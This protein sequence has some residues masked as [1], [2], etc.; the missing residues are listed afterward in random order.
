QKHAE[1]LSVLFFAF[2][3]AVVFQ[4]IATSLT[5]QGIATGGPYDNAAAYP[6]AIAILMGILLVPIAL[7]IKSTAI[8]VTF[9]E[10]KR[11]ALMLVIFSLYLLGLGILGY[12]ISTPLMLISV[13]MI[14]GIRRPIELVLSGIG[15]SLLM[16]L[17]FES[18][19]KVVLPGGMLGLH[20]AW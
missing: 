11:P 13:M 15:V 12:H 10:L 7:T 19:L 2:I 14:S 8:G 3:I 16:S 4:Q 17:C 18:M 20:I 9:A 5:E 6:K 1:W